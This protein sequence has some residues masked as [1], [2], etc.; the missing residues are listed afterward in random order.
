MLLPSWIGISVTLRRPKTY[1]RRATSR[2]WLESLENRLAPAATL[3][4]GQTFTFINSADLPVEVRVAGTAGEVFFEENRTDGIGDDDGILEDGEEIG[5]VDIRNAS[6]DFALTFATPPDASGVVPLGDMTAHEQTI[7]GIFTEG[8]CDFELNSFTG[9]DFS[10]GGG[11]FVHSVLRKIVLTQLSSDATVAVAGDLPGE[12]VVQDRLSGTLSVGGLWAGDVIIGGDLEGIIHGSQDVT[13]TVRIIG[14]LAGAAEIGGATRGKWLIVGSFTGQIQ[15]GTDLSYISVIRDF[16]GTVESGG[17]VWLDVGGTIA[18]AATIEGGDIVV[19]SGA[20]YSGRL[21]ALGSAYVRVAEKITAE[22]FAQSDG[23]MT[24][25]FGA[26]LDANA[27][28]TAPSL[29]VNNVSTL[30]QGQIIGSLPYL[31]TSP[32][33]YRLSKSLTYFG[34]AGVAIQVRSSNVTIDLQGFSL[35]ND[36]GSLTGAVGIT[37]TNLSNVTIRNGAIR[38]FRF[39]IVLNGVLGSGHVVEHIRAEANWYFG[40]WVEGARSHT[41][42]NVILDNGGLTTGGSWTIPI[43]MRTAGSDHRVEDNIIAGARRSVQNIEWVGAHLDLAPNLLF[44]GNLVAASALEPQTYGVWVNDGTWGL[45]GRT[46]VKINENTFVHMEHAVVVG[47]LGTYAGNLLLDVTYGFN[48]PSALDGGGNVAYPDIL[49][50]DVLLTELAAL[51]LGFGF[52]R[53]GSYYQNAYGY[54]EK[55]FQDRLAQWYV[56]LPDGTLYR[57]NGLRTLTTSPQIT[58]LPPAVFDDPTRLFSAAPPLSAEA[59][60]LLTQLRVAHGFR[61]APSYYEN[62]LGFREKWFFDRLG[63]WYAITPDGSLYRWNGQRNLTGSTLVA[64]LSPLIFD[65]PTRLFDAAVSLSSPQQQELQELL[66]THGFH[67]GASY[68]EN[69]LGFREK[70]LLDRLGN[71]YAITPDGSL[72][73]WNGLRNLNSSTRVRVLSPLVFDDPNHLLAVSISLPTQLQE[74]LGQLQQSHGF[75]PAQTYY[76]NAFGYHEKWFLDRQGAWFVLIPDGSLYRWNGLRNV[77]SGT[78]LA[79]LDPLVFDDP[80]RLFQARVPLAPDTQLELA[81]LEQ[82]FGFHF[83]G[84]FSENALG[85]GEKWFQDRFGLWHFILPDGRLFQWDR[86]SLTTSVR[87]ATLDALV[88]ENPFLLFD[89]EA[90]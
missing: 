72:Y 63:A 48:A 89:A 24:V 81:H 3:T 16:A 39:G 9:Q 20:N 1:R 34:A 55:W 10:P 77:T 22:A 37:G 90:P 8:P 14:N 88:F 23:P 70:W 4:P 74:L 17:R 45:D 82:A 11:L 62:A 15:T 64:T 51:Q 36:A 21:T 67:R 38:G 2:L 83:T 42:H 84:S 56:L 29:V 41:R 44:S 47:A 28:L 53:V 27:Q 6:A 85:Y 60:D 75:R 35:T 80:S 32:G 19:F 86:T 33:A 12:L 30:G 50:P 79:V 18:S 31:I 43:G 52:H 69:A 46:F 7:L 78:R 5:A 71:W 61:P 54:G 40:L 76:E 68:Y 26:T 58:S 65:D 49:G 13:G 66:T 73:Q 25:S 87:V 57:W 59:V